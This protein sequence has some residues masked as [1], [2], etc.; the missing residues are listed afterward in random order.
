M[1]RPIALL[2]ALLIAPLVLA[3]GCSFFQPKDERSAEE[4][5][6]EG[7]ESFRRGNYRASL[8]AFQKIK[9]W[10][11][12]SK[13]AIL[14]ELK[15]GDAHYALEEYEEAA[16]AYEEFET[17]HPKNE[18]IPYVIYQIGR[19]HFDRMNTV[20]R[21]Q[22][23]TRKALDVFSRLKKQFP[24]DPY[25][26]KAEEHIHECLR[27][28]A[29][30]DFYVGAFYFKSGRYPAAV[31]RFRAVINQYPDTGLHRRALDYLARCEEKLSRAAQ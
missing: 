11:P 6:V 19:C 7:S 13:Y 22:A 17:L 24:Q 8:E 28:L 20:D 26:R 29:G 3:P 9:D 1:M 21:D 14:A 30:H 4:L 12:F 10:Y 15:T 16:A 31:K 27:S 18:K 5:A 2:A 25:A 23:P